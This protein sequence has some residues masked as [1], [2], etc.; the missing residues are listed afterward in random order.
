[1]GKH[2]TDIQHDNGFVRSHSE[3]WGDIDYSSML[4]GE[5][6]AALTDDELH[7]SLGLRD[8]RLEVIYSEVG[9]RRKNNK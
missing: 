2:T 9:S 8:R 3:L 4:H 6:D 5:I 1:M 7:D